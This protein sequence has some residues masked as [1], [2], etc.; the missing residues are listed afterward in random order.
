MYTSRFYRMSMNS[1]RFKFFRVVNKET[2]LY[3]GV[4]HESFDEKMPETAY[5]SIICL[6]GK[7][8]QYI[9]LHPGFSASLDP[10]RSN[11]T[12]PDCIKQ[13]CD[14]SVKA[15]VGPMAGIAGLFAKRIGMDLK[16]Q[17]DLK[18]I[19]VENGG[20]LFI[21]IRKKLKLAIYAGQSSL[22]HKIA[23]ELDEINR[24]F[25]VCT[26][27]GTVGHSLSFGKADAFTIVCYDSVLADAFATSFANK[28]HNE[29]D[30]QSQVEN[31]KLN[32]EIL[33]SLAIKGEKLALQG[34]FQ[35]SSL[36]D[37]KS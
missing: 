30:L 11:K 8:E 9:Q 36:Q 31:T 32:T 23:L 34:R 29:T 25:S 12:Q 13:L 22:S 2:D 16:N 35:I 14:A 5:K 28:I 26:S 15:N 17:F 37:G 3:I 27:S 24:P 10:I 18:E 20:D 33:V 7:L 4:D 19:I 1:R 21:K 6:R